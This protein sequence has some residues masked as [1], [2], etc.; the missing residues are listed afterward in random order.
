MKHIP[1]EAVQNIHNQNSF[2]QFLRDHLGWNIQDD[3]SFDDLTFGWQPEEMGLKSDDLRGSRI[4]Q[5]RPFTNDQPWGIFF[6]HLA[7]P[8]VDRKSVV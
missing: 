7:K 3:I 6:I 5:L 4:S 2:F 1:S 8:Q